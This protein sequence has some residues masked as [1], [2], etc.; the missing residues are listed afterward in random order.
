MVDRC[1]LLAPVL[2]S[3]AGFT[4]PP[5]LLLWYHAIVLANIGAPCAALQGAMSTNDK[6]LSTL[7]LSGAVV[8]VAALGGYL[9]SQAPLKS[10]RPANPGLERHEAV[11]EQRALARLWQDPLAAVDAHLKTQ[12]ARGAGSVARGWKELAEEI[13]G[14]LIAKPSSAPLLSVLLV[15]TDGSP[16]VEGTEQRIRD[17]Y[18]VGAALS[19]ACYVPEDGDHVGYVI[20]NRSDPPSSI[21]FEWYRPRK[22]RDCDPGAP[23]S[24]L[25]GDV[26]V[27]WLSDEL[28]GDHPLHDLAALTNQLT[29]LVEESPA[30]AGSKPVGR[31]AFRIVGPPGSAMLRSMVSE[32][33]EN[34]PAL[35][36]P[37]AR[38]DGT[39]GLVPLYSPWASVSSSIIYQSIEGAR[40]R[41]EVDPDQWVRDQLRRGGL[42]LVYRPPTDFAL[43][44]TLLNEM[45]LR[46][47]REGDPIAII[48]EWDTF[49]GRNLPLEFSVAAC[50][51][52]HRGGPA[53]R[54]GS[55][56][57]GLRLLANPQAQ[58]ET[59]PWIH[60]YTY[61]RGLDGELPGG[62]SGGAAPKKAKK[63]GKEADRSLDE[64]ERPEGESQL[65]YVRRL[66]DRMEEDSEGRRFKAV[67]ILGSDV[68]DKLLI[69]QALRKRFPDT[70]F[71]TTDLDARLLHPSQYDWTHNLLIASHFGLELHPRL[72][73]EIPP[74]RNNYQSSTFFAVLQALGHVYR[75]CP[76]CPYE[77]KGSDSAAL[78]IA[79][80][81]AVYEVGRTLLVPLGAT[82]QALNPATT[83]TTR[84]RAPTASRVPHVHWARQLATSRW[85]PIAMAVFFTFC[86]IVPVIRSIP[87]EILSRETAQFV[88]QAGVGLALA[89]VVAV[90]G[91]AWAAAQPNGEPLFWLE[92]VSIWPT[93]LIRLLTAILCV[94]FF[95]LG[96]G[97]L[98]ANHATLTS[99]YGLTASE[100]NERSLPSTPAHW[101]T[102]LHPASWAVSFSGSA[103]HLAALWREHDAYIR[104][105]WHRIVPQTA[106]LGMLGGLLLILFGMPHTPARGAVAWW[107]NA[108]VWV[109]STATL[110]LLVFYVVDA[111]RVST[112]F[113][114]QFALEQTQWPA[115]IISPLSEQRKLPAD[116]IGEWLDIT[117]IAERTK[118]VG[119]LILIVATRNRIFDDWSYPPGLLVIFAVTAAYILACAV[120][121]S[122]AAEKARG[123]AVKRLRDQIYSLRAKAQEPGQGERCNQQ[124]AQIDQMLRDI[125]GVR[126]GAFAHWSQHPVFQA[127]L[128]PSGGFSALALLDYFL[129]Q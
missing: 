23:A 1:R 112:G 107:V 19:A 30:A 3:Q 100:N 128:L 51:N 13:V 102:W 58:R 33:K 46:R 70:L 81:P 64:L 74:F 68:Y 54:C 10:S 96:H 84:G 63:D 57:Q 80:V 53:P 20:W 101:L 109:L 44:Q 35:S 17:R 113:I 7:A 52:G 90:L 93:E 127:L 82:L 129:T 39:D 9:W 72:Q 38:Q 11:V 18:A 12:K 110:G 119:S 56:L 37:A 36:W 42:D 16:Y 61:L 106:V 67:G 108:V 65:D 14:K 92:G 40:A 60:H 41:E 123:S 83:M 73:Q 15:M 26:L 31:L 47:V 6:D 45:H 66:A 117:F 94:A 21:P 121:L 32:A 27:L 122:F 5:Q 79:T 2:S 118:V 69:L 98:T 91:F 75:T 8:L 104:T 49:Y 48:A 111:I 24:T 86:L 78:D 85:L 88:L 77:I 22:L 124:I 97:L 4:S 34:R 55:H 87:E 105:Q 99:R 103:K 50:L 29:R 116:L 76:A 71:F 120:L 115:E 62:E 43:A 89:A 25:F 95:R 114:H 28:F 125:E 59:V 126:Q